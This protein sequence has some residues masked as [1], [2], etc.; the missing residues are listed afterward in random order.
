MAAN[1][2]DSGDSREEIMRATHRALCANGF[3]NLTMQ[4]IADEMG[5]SRTLI[6]YHYDT[7]EELLETFLD[8]MIGWLRDRLAE[9]D[10]EHPVDRL[11]EFIDFFVIDPAEEGESLALAILEMRL[12]AIHNDTFREKLT[13]HYQENVAAAADILEDGVEEEVFRNVDPTAVARMIWRVAQ[14]QLFTANGRQRLSEP[15]FPTDSFPGLELE[16]DETAQ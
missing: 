4:D 6:H 14:D 3:A 10:T 16:T 13:I 1:G 11:A 7:K 12:Q 2:E 9:S 15:T 5:K 8:R